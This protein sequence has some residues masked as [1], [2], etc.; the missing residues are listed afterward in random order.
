MVVAQNEL[1][2]QTGALVKTLNDIVILL[3]DS[4]I[5][6]GEVA[7]QQLP[8]LIQEVIN[9][10]IA[11]LV[12]Y[13]GV[14]I[15]AVL[16]ASIAIHFYSKFIYSIFNDDAGKYSRYRNNYDQRELSIDMQFFTAVI[17]IL[18]ILAIVVGAVMIV[19]CS[20]DLIS[21]L[22]APRV[23]LITYFTN[24]VGTIKTTI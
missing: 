6:V 8:S 10:R 24:L 20:Y 2:N 4:A 17:Y 16:G 1:L 5:K 22:V 13:I 18:A 7:Q 9:L 12:F 23:Y 11:Q 19:S 14:G 3:K 15:I 21:V